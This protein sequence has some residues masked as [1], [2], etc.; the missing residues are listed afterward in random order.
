MPPL[1]GA[2]VHDVPVVGARACLRE[3]WIFGLGL[4][5]QAH[6]GIEERSGEAFLGD[7][8]EPVLRVHRAERSQAA[9]GGRR[10]P[11]VVARRAHRGQSAEPAAAENF[12][13]ASRDL[14][15][16]ESLGVR[17]NSDRAVLVLRFDITIPKAGVLEDMPVGIDSAG[18]RQFLDFVETIRH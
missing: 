16:F 8:F 3:F 10:R 4:P 9:V 6:G 7:S 11:L 15:I 17:A 12:R 13:R 18:E 1:P 14:E 2:E 5:Q